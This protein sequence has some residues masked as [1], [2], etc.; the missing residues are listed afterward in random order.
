MRV[1]GAETQGIPVV[2]LVSITKGDPAAIASSVRFSIESIRDGPCSTVLHDKQ[3]NCTG[4]LVDHVQLRAD[5]STAMQ[6]ADSDKLFCIACCR[7]YKGDHF[8]MIQDRVTVCQRTNCKLYLRSGGLLREEDS[9]TV[10]INQQAVKS[11]DPT[12]SDH[13]ATIQLGGDVCATRI[14]GQLISAEVSD[15]SGCV[16]NKMVVHSCYYDFPLFVRYDTLVG[17]IFTAPINRKQVLLGTPIVKLLKEN[18]TQVGPQT[19]MLEPGYTV[20]LQDRRAHDRTLMDAHAAMIQAVQLVELDPMSVKHSPQVLLSDDPCSEVKVNFLL[21]AQLSG[22][23]KLW[24]FKLQ[25]MHHI[26]ALLGRHETMSNLKFTFQNASANGAHVMLA[27]IVAKGFELE[28]E[29]VQ[30]RQDTLDLAEDVT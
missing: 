27:F 22:T 10:P 23:I 16:F 2:N 20:V 29:I 24:S 15:V 30:F 21:V 5:I 19:I 1:A 25:T 18:M 13:S 4:R 9:P 12:G 6:Y 28:K 3:I 8:V 14:Q 26:C 17:S 7:Y 11:L